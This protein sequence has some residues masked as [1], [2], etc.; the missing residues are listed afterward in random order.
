M[1]TGDKKK[2]KDVWPMPHRLDMVE[3]PNQTWLKY[4]LERYHPIQDDILPP[5]NNCQGVL[6]LI[7]FPKCFKN[8][9]KYRVFKHI[10]N[11]H[12]SYKL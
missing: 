5:L 7:L 9:Y 6:K 3:I 11:N 1:R 4:H 8:Q 10:E 2:L 12:S